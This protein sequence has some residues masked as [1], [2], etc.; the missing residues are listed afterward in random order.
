M[1]SISIFQHSA[2]HTQAIRIYRVPCLWQGRFGI[3]CTR[4][5]PFAT[6]KGDLIL[7][8]SFSFDSSNASAP[9]TL[10]LAVEVQCFYNLIYVCVYMLCVV[11]LSLFFM[12]TNN[13]TKYDVIFYILS[14]KF[15][16]N[17][18]LY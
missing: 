10:N 1:H 13:E 12:K 14:D 2:S 5:T 4:Q 8:K 6:S 7:A 3:F 15:G 18:I 16:Y 17:N 9:L 11:L